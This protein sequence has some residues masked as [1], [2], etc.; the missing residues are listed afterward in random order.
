MVEQNSSASV[1]AEMV[2][3][4][5]LLI[6]AC[7]L[8][9][10]A[11]FRSQRASHLVNHSLHIRQE[12]AQLLST[13]E[14]A[15]TGQRGYLLT[16]KAR[17]LKPYLQAGSTIS[18]AEKALTTLV[19]EDPPQQKELAEL[20]PLIDKKLAEVKQSVALRDEGHA[21][22]SL[23][24]VDTDLGINLM[25]RIRAIT[26]KMDLEQSARQSEL[27][28]QSHLQQRLLLIAII[29]SIL[30][31]SALAWIVLRDSARKNFELQFKNMA[32]REEIKQREMAEAQ[33]R[34]A[35]KMEALG[36]LTGGIAHDFNN[37][38]A[39]VVGNLEMALR[40]LDPHHEQPHKFINNAL[41]GAL[42]AADLT[43]RLL[44]FS[45]RQPLKPSAIDMNQCVRDMS[46]ML[47]R[48]LGET[49]QIETVIAAGLWRA[50]VDR[51]QLESALLNLAVN[52]RDAMGGSGRLTIE[53]ANAYLDQHYA[54]IREEVLPGQYVMVA[55]TDT[56]SGMSPEVLRKAFDPF[57][58][59]KEVGHGTGLGLSQ[60]HGFVKQSRGHVEIYTEEGVGTT[61][62][63]Y[64]PRSMEE[65]TKTIVQE[66]LIAALPHKVL[67]VED[68]AEVRNFV[69]MALEELGYLSVQ[70]ES[71]DVAKE[72]LA[73]HADI[74]IL[75]TDVVMPGTNGKQLVDAIR[76]RYP[77]LRVLFMT[78]YTRNAI[79]H[80]GMLD[81]GV[82]LISKPFTIQE[83]AHELRATLNAD[84]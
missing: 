25:D 7:A 78:G 62:K 52:G 47:Q 58:T 13:V 3:G 4:F 68:D 83:L 9:V 18:E 77:E 26:T 73:E 44:A 42:K 59:T 31:A 21:D 80:N 57:F 55:V 10:V 45:R 72:K 19:Q 48:A 14:D 5:A 69:A 43:R 40:R 17:Y 37:M 24:L 12:V 79:V 49:V 15:E 38:L 29:V 66:E 63:L 23:A 56:G 75:L 41:T 46:S 2:I 28:D 65:E 67:V 54:A 35:Q 53:T 20:Y 82:R 6:L 27:V 16:G 51:P 76:S 84:D 61:V 70:A 36:Q 60:V 39:V 34:Q 1:K 71:A 11:T 50:Y 81:P 22:A 33:L 74:S 30:F 32:L 64:L 8:A